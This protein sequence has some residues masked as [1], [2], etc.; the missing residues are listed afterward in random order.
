MAV[1]PDNKTLIPAETY[2]Q[3][4]PPFDIATD[5]TLSGQRVRADLDGGFP[6]G[7]CLKAD[8]AIWYADVPARRCVRVG[9]GSQVAAHHRTRPRLLRLRPRRPRQADTIHGGDCPGHA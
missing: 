4:S 2:A 3:G 5:G 9:E 6:G 7:I 8:G 1:T